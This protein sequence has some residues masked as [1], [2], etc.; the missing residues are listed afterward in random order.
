MLKQLLQRIFPAKRDLNAEWNKAKAVYEDAVRRGDTRAQHEAW[1]ALREAT[2]AL[3]SKALRKT[4]A[5]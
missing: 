2:N 5:R 3:L 4:V 1:P